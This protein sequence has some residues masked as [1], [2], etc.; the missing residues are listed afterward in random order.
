MNQ[1][2]EKVILGIDPGTNVL[3]YGVIRTFGKNRVE[4]VVMGIIELSKYSIITL[5]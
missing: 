3:G 1:Q 4:L 2:P 5:N